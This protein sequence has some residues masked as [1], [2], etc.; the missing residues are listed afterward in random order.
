V[1]IKRVVNLKHCG[2]VRAHGCQSCANCVWHTTFPVNGLVFGAACGAADIEDGS[3]FTRIRLVRFT[4]TSDGTLENVIAMADLLNIG[5]ISNV[6]RAERDAGRREQE[7]FQLSRI[8]EQIES[9]KTQDAK[10]GAAVRFQ[11]LGGVF[12]FGVGWLSDERQGLS[13]SAVEKARRDVAIP[14]PSSFKQGSRSKELLCVLPR[15]CC[16]CR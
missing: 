8:A 2:G 16:S 4:W 6:S 5:E 13:V 14:T 3:P 11:A 15:L 9:I 1:K 10:S 7:H 12:A